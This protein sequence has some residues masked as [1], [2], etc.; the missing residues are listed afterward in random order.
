MRGSTITWSPCQAISWTHGWDSAK[1]TDRY[2]HHCRSGSDSQS[3]SRPDHQSVR[4][5]SQSAASINHS[6]DHSQTLIAEVSVVFHCAA[7]V[8]F[9]EKL[10]ISI[11]MNVLGTERLIDLCHDMTCLKVNY[12]HV[13][14]GW[15]SP[16]CGLMQPTNRQSY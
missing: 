7:T 13:A 3:L 11:E 12:T 1:P 15:L 2:L 5:V 10:R 16:R 8:K 6:M 4:R 9:D 14:S